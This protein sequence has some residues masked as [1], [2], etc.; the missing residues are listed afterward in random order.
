MK[1]KRFL[2]LP[3]AALVLAL[4]PIR[5]FAD[6]GA[7]DELSAQIQNNG[8]AYSKTFVEGGP[9]LTL[10]D[11]TQARTAQSG[12]A[13]QTGT[14][15]LYYEQW[16]DVEPPNPINTVSD[17]IGATTDSNRFIDPITGRI[18]GVIDGVTGR[19]NGAINKTLD[20]LLSPVDEAV[21]GAFDQ[22]D[23]AIDKAIASIM[24]PVDDIINDIMAGIDQKIESWVG[25]VFS[26]DGAVGGIINDV[27]GGLFGGIFGSGGKIE[28]EPAYNPT[29]R[30]SSIITA[31][32]FQAELEGMSAPYTEAIPFAMGSMGLP[33]YSKILPTLD[34]LAK[35]EK[36]NPNPMLQGLDRFSTT[37]ETLKMSLSGEVE[38][39][40]SR[41]IAQSVLSEAGQEDM[42]A[43]LDGA[44]NTLKTIMAI[45]EDSQ[46]L[47]V[48]QDVMKSLTAQL[49]N[50][51]V[52]RAGQ[53]KQDLLARQQ[54][55]ADA[56]VN[57]EIARLLGEQN[58]ASRADMAANASMMHNVAGQLHLPGEMP[59]D[60]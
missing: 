21:D 47:D 26:E 13:S 45:G 53:Y 10:N 31:T 23:G 43:Q 28:V 46:D 44:E 12:K 1:M 39:L 4:A 50:D 52:I 5:A 59:D 57:T 14:Q 30:L 7:L 34:A 48:T 35:G 33:D 41:S 29:S 24:A 42:K 60:D 11:L 18:D 58:R 27:T 22:V 55:A 17:R 15:Q 36:G 20:G 40:A 16:N 38:R 25:D 9:T 37:P 2:T 3:V 19:V 32:S 8:A 6:N 51:S 49:A 56:V 54:A